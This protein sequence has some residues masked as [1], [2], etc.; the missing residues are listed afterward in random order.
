MRRTQTDETEEISREND[1]N[2]AQVVSKFPLPQRSLEDG[3][4][5]F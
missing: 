2:E 4:H 3:G 5:L 1:K